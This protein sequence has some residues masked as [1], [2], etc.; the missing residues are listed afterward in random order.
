MV[1]LHI[2]ILNLFVLPLRREPVIAFA[3]PPNTTHI[4]QP[5]DRVCFKALKQCWDEQCN[6]FMSDNPG[7]TLTLC[8]FSELF[9]ATW[10]KAM[11]PQNI[12][13]SFRATGVFPVNQQ[14]LEILQ[15]KEKSPAKLSM[16]AIAKTNEIF[17]ATLQS[18][19]VLNQ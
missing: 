2:I 8:Q 16:V 11:T 17:F 6:L 3:L 15:V 14:A 12:T 19:E 18:Q 7:K 10:K 13:S 1:T 5:L 9:A 4:S